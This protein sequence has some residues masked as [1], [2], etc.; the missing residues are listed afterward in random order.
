MGEWGS[1][2][3]SAV[4]PFLM[5]RKA[6]LNIFVTLPET[7]STFIS[8]QKPLVPELGVVIDLVV[9]LDGIDVDEIETFT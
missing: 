2:P 5:K 1:S 6:P 4:I 7:D 3:L 8:L 9:V